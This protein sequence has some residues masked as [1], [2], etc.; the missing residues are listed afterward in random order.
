MTDKSI[1]I[2]TGHF[3]EERGAKNKNLGLTEWQLCSLISS[4]LQEKLRQKDYNVTLLNNEK[5]T[6]KVYTINLYKPDLALELHMNTYDTT[7]EG[8]LCL[9]WYNSTNGAVFAKNITEMLTYNNAYYNLQVSKKTDKGSFFLRKTTCPAVLIELCFIDN[10]Y[11][12]T[13]TMY[14]IKQVV[15]QLCQ[16]I[17]QSFIYLKPLIA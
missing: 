11:D 16:A 8:H 4:M 2:C 14:N 6:S 10:D 12:L 5:L 9:Y 1:V 13:N 7:K 15:I 17:D 3:K